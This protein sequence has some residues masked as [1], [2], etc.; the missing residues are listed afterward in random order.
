MSIQEL[1]GWLNHNLTL[2]WDN[3]LAQ[4]RDILRVKVGEGASK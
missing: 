2:N 3:D 4:V 1:I